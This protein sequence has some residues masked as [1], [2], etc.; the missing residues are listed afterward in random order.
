M[1]GTKKKRLNDPVDKAPPSIHD[2]GPFAKVGF[3]KG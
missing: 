2:I 1:S 3:S